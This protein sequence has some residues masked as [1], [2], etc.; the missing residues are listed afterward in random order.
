MG[1]AYAHDKRLIRDR[2]EAQRRRLTRADVARLSA[3]ACARVL[4]LPAFATAEHVVAYAAIGNELDPAAIADASRAGGRPVYYPRA[5]DEVPGFLRE[6]GR[7]ETLPATDTV[8]FL[9]PAVAFD[10][11]G[12]RLGRGRGWY[13]RALARY[14]SATRVG[15]GYDFQVVP[16][17]PEAPWDVRMHAVVTDARVIEAPGPARPLKEGWT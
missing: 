11:R 13:D 14:P 8:L 10:L 15:L 4:G 9:V 1:E 17:L 2:L 7:R 12:V 5:R 6:A 3:T 16:E